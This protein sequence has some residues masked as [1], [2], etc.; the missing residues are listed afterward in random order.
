MLKILIFHL[1]HQE[2]E[3]FHCLVFFRCGKIPLPDQEIECGFR[4]DGKRISRNMRDIE[5]KGDFKVLLPFLQGER[6][7]SIDQVDADV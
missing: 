3:L 4:L 1:F 7:N 2:P 6:W 5:R